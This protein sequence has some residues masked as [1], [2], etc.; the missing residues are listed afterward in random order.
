MC[1]QYVELIWILL[2]MKN[3]ISLKQQ[4]EMVVHEQNFVQ[5]SRRVRFGIFKMK[6]DTKGL[7]GTK[8][9]YDNG[10]VISID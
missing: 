8:S 6:E 9:Q 7:L 1:K 2:K 4:V 10:L 5:W 3:F